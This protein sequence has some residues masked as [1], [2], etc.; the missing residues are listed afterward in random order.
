MRK[1]DHGIREH[2]EQRSKMQNKG[3]DEFVMSEPAASEGAF[4]FPRRDTTFK[5]MHHAIL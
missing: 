2:D 3:P 5:T 4:P 1:L